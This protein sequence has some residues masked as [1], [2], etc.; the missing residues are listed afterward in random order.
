ML[1]TATRSA[2]AGSEALAA[3]ALFG[4]GNAAWSVAAS[5]TGPIFDAGA[6]FH[7]KESKVAA[8]EQARSQYR[9]TVITAFQNVADSLRAI[10]S[11]A[12]LLKAQLEAETVA[13]DSLTISQAQ[14]KAGST[15]FL[16]VLNAEQTLLNARVNRVKA[17]ATRYADTVALFQSL[18]GGWWNRVDEGPASQ[19][20][21]AGIAG[22]FVPAGALP[23]AAD[24]PAN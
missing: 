18:G 22:I 17:Q 5:V 1:P 9:S 13:N 16:T 2:S 15:T 7:T 12:V 21:P 8:L 10:Q 4:P 6:L 3:S 11:D 14:F 19:A 23:A 20:K 24:Q